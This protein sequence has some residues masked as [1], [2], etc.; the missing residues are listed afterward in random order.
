MRYLFSLCGQY[1]MAYGPV[2]G[3]RSG[4][5][6]PLPV[7]GSRPGGWETADLNQKAQDTH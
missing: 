6:G 7:R 1:Q 2:R 5:W 3:S 4:G